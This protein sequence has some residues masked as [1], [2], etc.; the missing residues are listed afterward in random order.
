MSFNV[1]FAAGAAGGTAVQQA[2][3]QSVAT[4]F[5]N[6]F[7]DNVSVDITVQFGTPTGGGL[8]S[9]FIPNSA[10]TNSTYAA[11]RTALL[12]DA[13]SADDTAANGTLPTADPITDPPPAGPNPHTYNVVQAEAMAMGMIP[14]NGNVNDGISTFSN[15]ALFDY[16]RSDGIAAGATDFFGV[17]AHEFSEIM[18]RATNAFNNTAAFGPGYRPLDLFS[19][20][21]LNTRGL[22][23]TNVHYFSIDSG[24]TNLNNFNTANNGDF[25]D[26]ANNTGNDA[27]RAFSPTDV[28]D[29]LSLTDL[30]EMDV[31]GWNVRETA[32]TVTALTD[33]I[34]K[35]AT[36][37]SQN[38]LQGTSDADNDVLFV[39][40][41]DT[42]VTT[43][44]VA[45]TLNLNTD[46]TFT[47]TPS[48][49]TLALTS[50]G[51]GK[52]S[53][54]AFN[55]TATATF[56]Y[57]VNDGITTTADTLTLNITGDHPPTANPD[58]DSVGEN[59][60]KS[61][62]VLANDTDPDVGD[63]KTLVS[64][65]KILVASG[66]GQINGIDATSA[67]SIINN[68][69]KFI[70]GTLFDPLA[71]GQTATATVDYT[72]EDSQ[73]AKSSS[74][75]TLT[76]NGQDD[77]PV[78]QTGGGGANA[79]YWVRVNNTAVT[80]VHATDVDSGDVVQY[81]ISGGRDANLFTIDN[82]TGALA[83]KDLPKQPNQTYQVQV[84]AGDGHAGGTD[85]QTL[86]V[87]VT[88]AQM[89]NDTTDQVSDTFVFHPMFGANIVSDFD[90]AHD[91]LQFDKGMFA[92]D[93]TAAVLKAA[94]DD[95][96]GNVV[97]NGTLAGTLKV[98]DTSV[99]ALTSHSGDI[100][101]V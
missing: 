52:F 65:D 16:D 59:E 10:T 90:V 61:I 22:V 6:H 24:A 64:I 30:R 73:H 57:N 43:T 92:A 47:G 75:L 85:V 25:G 15:T 76:I 50:T 42:S 37:F 11:I 82:K 86:T 1:T 96:H 94:Q 29:L 48:A 54:L 91:I 60:T 32:P 33:S 84:Q 97:I 7:L 26:W 98:L 51:L 71:V 36:S 63:T 8:G 55:Q 66:N 12:A 28:I 34:N 77:A 101:F 56:H 9:S 72:M 23:G 81:S 79:A 17:V 68:Q 27:F 14:D 100:Q 70:P 18:G 5:N 62:D 69:I 39:T 13:S 19:Y 78:I 99:A 20:S 89:G 83:F 74:H 2:A 3:V 87:N 93:T 38:L 41:L 44:G 46:Y 35:D 49:A 31:I 40:G 95:G 21:G 67:F 80:T 58:A 53:G 88:G 4:F 45:I